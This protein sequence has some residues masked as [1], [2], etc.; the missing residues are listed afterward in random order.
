MPL[1]GLSLYRAPSWGSEPIS[2]LVYGWR[3]A[4]VSTFVGAFSASLPAYITMIESAMCEVS[5]RSWVT[6]IM[7]VTRP[8]SRSP[9][10]APTTACWL[11]TSRAEVTSSAIRTDGSSSVEITMTARCF[12][13]PDSSIG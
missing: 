7:L 9:V 5:P 11:E 1:S 12:M 13:P 10:R 2:I 3:G 8:L 6:K 4:V